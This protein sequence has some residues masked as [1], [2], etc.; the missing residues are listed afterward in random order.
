VFTARYAL[1]PYIKQIS[2]VF[3]GLI[4]LFDL[5]LLLEEFYPHF[6]HCLCSTS[7]AYITIL[8]LMILKMLWPGRFRFRTSAGARFYARVQTGPEARP[9]PSAMNTGS[10][11]LGQCSR[12]VIST[13]HP[14]LTQNLSISRAI[15]QP[16][17]PFYQQHVT[18]YILFFI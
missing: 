18:G 10:L 16:P 17:P 4:F 8:Y 13:T 11:S 12:S 7:L 2:F 9:V 15:T 14:Q 5:R 6:L 3:K 1:N